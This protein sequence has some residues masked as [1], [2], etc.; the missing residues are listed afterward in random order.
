MIYAA[1]K[2]NLKKKVVGVKHE[3]QA[4]ELSDLSRHEIT[5]KIKSRTK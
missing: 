3:I 4:T 2:D 1:S 5:E